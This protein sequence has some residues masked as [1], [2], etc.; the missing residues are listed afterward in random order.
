MN[1]DIKLFLSSTFDD[2]MQDERD[3][4]RNEI[5]TELNH[6]VGQVGK[7]L[8]LYDYVLGIS[9]D[10]VFSNV[11]DICFR[12]VDESDFFVG[13]VG[14][15]YG[16]HVN[17]KLKENYTGKYKELIDEGIRENLSVLELE[18]IESLKNTNQKKLFFIQDAITDSNT[19]V[20]KLITRIKTNISTNISIFYYSK[21]EN[22]LSELKQYFENEFKNE[23]DKFTTERKNRNLV[24]ANKTRYYVPN[25][26]SQKILYE[27]DDYVNNDSR[28]IFVLSGDAGSGKRTVLSQWIQQEKKNVSSSETK[29]ISAFAGVEGKTISDILLKI[30]CQAPFDDKLLSINQDKKDEQSLLGRFAQFTLEVSKQFQ[31]TIIII[32]GI[33]LLEFTSDWKGNKYWWL[34]KQLE[35]NV[36]VIV[37][38]TDNKFDET[39]FE[40]HKILFQ[41]LSELIETYLY[42]EGKEQ[43][44]N[45]FRKKLA[46]EAKDDLPVFARLLCTE[47]CMTAK[48]D[49]IDRILD[50]YKKFSSTGKSDILSLYKEFLT[51]LAKRQ[52]LKNNA[53]QE[54]CHYLYYSENGLRK[55]TLQQ[56]FKDGDNQVNSFYS[57]LY[58]ELIKNVDD[59]I[60]F[61]T[62][63]F[64]Q[65][66]KE[67]YIDSCCSI[68]SLNHKETAYRTAIINELEK[69]QYAK[70]RGAIAER[71]YQIYQ[72][73]DKQRMYDLL[74]D[75]D[76]ADVL[77]WMNRIRFLEYLNL[78]EDKD[79]LYKNKSNENLSYKIVLFLS[80]YYK[81]ISNYNESLVWFK[82]TLVINEKALGKEHPNTATTYNN[83]GEIYRVQ[84]DYAFALEYYGKALNIVEKVLGTE[85]P[86]IA[87]SYN[88][89]AVVYNNKGDYARALEN[90]EKALN[91]REKVLGKEHPDT[92]T[93]YNNMGIVYENKS[94]YA[95]AL[96]YYGK[97]IDIEEKALGTEHLDTAITYINMAGV[98]RAQ[99]NYAYA[100]EYYRKALDIYEKVLG[101]EHFDTVTPYNNMA[102]VY[103]DKGDYA[104]ALEYYEKALDIVEKVLGTEH[105]YAAS[106]YNNMA[107]IYRTQGDYARALEYYE[108]AL[109]IKE[110]VLSTEHPDVA[111]TYNNMGEIYYYKGDY[112]R[113][114]EY[115]GKA[116]DIKEKVLGT[117]H[118]D[119][120]TTYN[121]IGMVYDKKG[122][123]ARAL[124]YYGKDLA[125]SEK[126]LGTEHPDTATTYNNIGSVHNHKRDYACA[127]E[128]YGKALVIRKKA[129][130]TGHL[131]TA[132]TYNDMAVVYDNKGDYALALEY[133]GKALD[134]YEKVLGT[135]HPDTATPYNNI[136]AVYYHTGDYAR[137]LEY[138][139][140]ALNIKEKVLGTEHP[141][142]VAIY[143][144]IAAVY[145]VQGN[146]DRT[147]E[148][149]LKSMPVFIK[150]FGKTHPNT[151]TVF[152]NIVDV[153]E[154]IGNP[155]LFDEW[156]KKNL[157]M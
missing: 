58:H 66:V 47:I 92:A 103:S 13:I 79:N 108:K 122:D 53:V 80:F 95:R 38:A 131:Y 48:Y 7:N 77:Y 16:T 71:A 57:L 6:I 138:Y 23:I 121:N 56:F 70:E 99:G 142:T 3:F 31:K 50:E 155:E 145:R 156:L 111:S 59:K 55:R 75:I 132:T 76:N 129:L 89:M 33:N 74:S 94:D 52:S 147:L 17:D 2:K 78:I 128:Y 153:Y 34:N 86:D 123:F 117:E 10:E 96:V 41:N 39:R 72:I 146:Y 65:A 137:A 51:R 43:I 149:Y 63:Y 112:A 118:P 144:N 133:Y 24:Y 68:C 104:R 64:R 36:K 21:Y 4:F 90:Y 124:E 120:A 26:S 127:L 98:Y 150:V 154:Q 67:L 81:E 15:N 8:F 83:I 49:T 151:E 130:G 84:G 29:I 73:S 5:N 148:W 136:A 135:E 141:D 113:A 22:I 97:A 28:K 1:K 11:L 14:N 102:G 143:N 91:I 87:T 119:T 82:N 116:L 9:K 19:E 93:T 139:G 85:H 88:N 126:I 27:L 152:K 40:V 62:V 110:K 114:L 20:Q 106:T 60:A 37:S 109:N 101:T 44:Y 42:K 30:Y 107:G 46:F 61:S 45:I 12:K 105:P 35:D 100:L 134:I 157:M 54:I 25:E 140:K 125:I 18:F 32:D 115:Y 69:S